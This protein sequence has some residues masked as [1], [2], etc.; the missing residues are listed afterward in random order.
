MIKLDNT[1]FFLY[2]NSLGW[3][4]WNHDATKETMSWSSREA[5][6]ESKELEPNGN[7]CLICKCSDSS[8]F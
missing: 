1:T 7:K 6:E 8:D 4:G 2:L 3:N 5:G